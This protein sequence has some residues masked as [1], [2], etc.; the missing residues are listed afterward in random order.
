MSNKNNFVIGFDDYEREYVYNTDDI[1]DDRT[2]LYSIESVAETI[3]QLRVKNTINEFQTFPLLIPSIS[4]LI[5]QYYHSAVKWQFHT[6]PDWI[7]D[8]YWDNFQKY[9]V[10]KNALNQISEL[11]F[12]YGNELDIHEPTYLDLFKFWIRIGNEFLDRSVGIAD[13][14]WKGGVNL[15]S[16]STNPDD[17][18]ITEDID[19]IVSCIDK[20]A[21]EIEDYEDGIYGAERG[22][23]SLT[24]ATTFKCLNDKEVQKF[25]KEE[26]K[27]YYLRCKK[28][29]KFLKSKY[30]KLTSLY[31]IENMVAKTHVYRAMTKDLIE[32]LRVLKALAVLMEAHPSELMSVYLEDNPE[33]NEFVKSTIQDIIKFNDSGV[34]NVSEDRIG[35]KYWQTIKGKINDPIDARSFSELT[36]SNITKC[37]T[38][39]LKKSVGLGLKD[40]DLTMIDIIIKYFY[41]MGMVYFQ[42]N[43]TLLSNRGDI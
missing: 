13:T 36:M 5:H 16:G 26:V 2:S 29:L 24:P 39:Y 17:P 6:D 3:K 40:F 14:Y 4:N 31:R 27:D 22:V 23:Y 12:P 30:V 35:Y 41:F 19:K 38:I 25:S 34:G 18:E 8:L 10:A 20:I 11:L 15:I 42:M 9:E 1:D 43:E 32:Y 21:K 7:G 33:L 28:H 37:S